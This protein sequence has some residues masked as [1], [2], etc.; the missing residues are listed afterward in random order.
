MGAPA[1]AVVAFA[2]RGRVAEPIARRPRHALSRCRHCCQ[3]GPPAQPQHPEH[4]QPKHH[5]HRHAKCSDGS[6]RWPAQSSVQVRCVRV[7]PVHVQHAVA[8]WLRGTP[9]RG[10][11]RGS[12][13]SAWHVRAT[14]A[15][16][17][18]S[19]HLLHTFGRCSGRKWKRMPVCT[20]CGGS[21]VQR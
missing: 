12:V 1:R 13:L 15:S 9:F 2:D 21:T 18:L 14:G 19:A 8:F 11:G 20:G 6:L 16:V 3:C 5:R 10:T 17:N 4:H 7:W